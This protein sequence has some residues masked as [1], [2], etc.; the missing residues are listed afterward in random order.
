MG[1]VLA[2][3]I[4]YNELFLSFISSY[5]GEYC[6]STGCLNACSNAGACIQG[7]CH[8]NEGFKDEVYYY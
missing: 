1:S 3:G 7:V 4:F 5:K 6:E 8:C 2:K